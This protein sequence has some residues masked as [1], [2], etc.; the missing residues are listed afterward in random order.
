MHQNVLSVAGMICEMLEARPAPLP[1]A[2]RLCSIGCGSGVFDKETLEEVQLKFPKIKFHYVGFDINDMS[3]QRARKCVGTLSGVTAETHTDDIQQLNVA[4]FEPF[5]M[6]T[7]VHALYYA[8]VSLEDALRNCVKLTKPG[9][10]H[11]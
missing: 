1:S 4:A 2:F 10:K 7:C 3:C 8:Q 9:G 6:V 11:M 5:D